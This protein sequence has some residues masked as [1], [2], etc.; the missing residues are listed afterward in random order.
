M[1]NDDSS[2]GTDASASDNHGADEEQVY[3]RRVLTIDNDDDVS[4][5]TTSTEHSLSSSEEE[6]L[7]TISDT[8]IIDNDAS[9]TNETTYVRRITVDDII[10]DSIYHTN[11]L[12]NIQPQFQH[13]LQ[14]QQPKIPPLVPISIDNPAIYNFLP[15]PDTYVPFV[16][17]AISAD[18]WE[19]PQSNNIYNNLQQEEMRQ[20]S[21]EQSTNQEANQPR[22]RAPLI[23]THRT[24]L[25]TAI[26]TAPIGSI[27]IPLYHSA[28]SPIKS[29][30]VPLT[31]S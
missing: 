16:F 17:P 23:V 10:T 25:P 9:Q 28:L 27:N 2:N 1:Y 30:N 8:S 7:D 19:I 12:A 6:L 20:P 3:A 18:T 21:A 13:T 11:N 4:V 29:T 15:I 22:Q 31:L 24:C 14:Y 26:E 5:M